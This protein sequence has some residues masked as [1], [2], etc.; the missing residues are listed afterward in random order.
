[1]HLMSDPHEVK[2]HFGSGFVD[3]SGPS[4]IRCLSRKK[5]GLMTVAAVALG[6]SVIG[7]AAPSRA[8]TEGLERGFY[9][10]DQYPCD[11]A[12]SVGVLSYDG[13]V[14]INNNV[15]CTLAPK[16]NASG[17][18]AVRCVEGQD[19]ATAETMTWNF[20]KISATKFKINGNIFRQCNKNP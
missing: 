17:S 5:S 10:V 15:A 3:G 8:Q 7:F 9:V 6:S 11:D 18:F 19:A 12:P 13:K 4:R 14:F 1:M 20:E 16:P 2:N